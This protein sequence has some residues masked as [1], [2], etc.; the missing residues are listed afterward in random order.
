M[1]ALYLT[2]P[3]ESADDDCQKQVIVLR[4]FFG[5]TLCDHWCIPYS[6]EKLLVKLSF[7]SSEHCVQGLSH[8][9]LLILSLTVAISG[10]QRRI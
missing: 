6:V 2:P 10:Y 7:V 3:G 9:F 8:N 4:W 5:L 1:H